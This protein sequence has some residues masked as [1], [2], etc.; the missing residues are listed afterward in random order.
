MDTPSL[1]DGKNEFTSTT[2]R[3]KLSKMWYQIKH[4]TKQAK[5]MYYTFKSNLKIKIH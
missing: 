2:L 3:I 5:F 1:K 4:N